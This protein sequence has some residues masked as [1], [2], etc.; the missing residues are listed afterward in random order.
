MF[1]GAAEGP[2]SA[3]SSRTSRTSSNR[4]D[5]AGAALEWSFFTGLVFCVL[6]VRGLYALG[7][8]AMPSSRGSR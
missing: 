8:A 6:F 5:V 2:L 1:D 3:T 4:S 7:V